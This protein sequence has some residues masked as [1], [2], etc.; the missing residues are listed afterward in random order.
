MA[1][2]QLV[3]KQG[4]VPGKTF[5]LSRDE[6]SIGRDINN[7]IV[8]NDAEIS[9]RHCRLILQGD[10]YV[11]ED[12]GSTNGTF[13][14]EQ[15]VT[16]QRALRSGETLRVGDNVTLVYEQ[17]GVDADAT[18]ASR[19]AQAPAPP[20]QPA[21]P[22]PQPRRQPQQYAGQVPAG[23][24]P[25]EPKKGASRGLMIG[26]GV[27]LVVGICVLAG[28]LYYIDANYMWCDIFGSL[29]PGCP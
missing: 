7:E 4:P 9:R 13:V 17:A 28:G 22:P 15:R 18:L 6:L 5:E 3:M 16:G 20:P 1:Q 14:N 11:I 24:A 12:L 26:C 27:L 2:Y 19:G 8:I 10:G 25:A 29:I 23:P 21:A